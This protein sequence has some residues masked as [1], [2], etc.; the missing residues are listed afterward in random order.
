MPVTS[1]EGTPRG[2][3]IQAVRHDG[4]WLT[5]AWNDG[6]TS[7]FPALWL[8]DNVP[9]GRH[10]AEGQRLFDV[11]DLPEET[12][13]AH[14]GLTTGGAILVTFCPEG[15]ET[16]FE[17]AWLHD[18]G[19]GA[20]G[21]A[22]RHPPVRTWG[23]E[24]R[25]GLPQAAYAEIRGSDVE[26]TRW[27]RAV[28][29]HGFALLHGVP[30]VPGQVLEVVRLF[31]F[32]RET[33]YGRLFDVVSENEPDNLAYSGMALGLH[34][35]NPYRDPV[36]GL[37]LLHCLAASADGGES[38]FADGFRAAERLRAESPKD[39][40]LL[41]RYG[42]P[43][44]YRSAGIDLRSRAPLIQVDEHDHLVAV[45][46]NNR[47]VAPL[48]L[49]EDVLPDFYCAYRRFARLLNDPDGLVGFE[50]GPGD[51]FIVDNQ[52]VL[53]GRRD[54]TGGR[55]HLQGCYADKDS[56]LSRLRI[57]ETRT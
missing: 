43:F 2:A 4:E 55:R 37:Q 36:P 51:L 28:R 41:A 19:L 26:L 1:S 50:L 46:Y 45:R 25:K 54:F 14:A 30:A 53:H 39:F 57:L 52:R 49:G 42:V 7:R 17:A 47:S 23:S 32:V 48:D 6:T 44:R 9:F 31:G 3:A 12:G 24:L 40:S 27:L 29:D 18:H 33:N 11:A 10:K 21:A 16:V 35:D 20:A 13:I 56:L 8:R 22:A 38:L 15:L 34:T 5:L